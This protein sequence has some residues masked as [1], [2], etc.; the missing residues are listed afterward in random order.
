MGLSGH[1]FP[2]SGNVNKLCCNRRT[3]CCDGGMDNDKTPV[4]NSALNLT[5]FSK[6]LHGE[7][8]RQSLRRRKTNG[9]FGGVTK[10]ERA[11]RRLYRRVA[12]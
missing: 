5:E 9:A 12:K 7:S 10:D 2:L 4:S 11:V 3:G 1:D 8:T 6:I